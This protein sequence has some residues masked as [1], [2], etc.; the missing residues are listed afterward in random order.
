MSTALTIAAVVLGAAFV[1][2]LVVIICILWQAR[3]IAKELRADFKEQ[4]DRIRADFDQ[5][6]R[7]AMRR[8]MPW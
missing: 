4:R 3:R 8:K 7:L 2:W 5:Q 1:A 6:S